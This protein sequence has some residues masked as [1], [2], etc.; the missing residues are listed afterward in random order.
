MNKKILLA[1]FIIVLV[2]I[3]GYLA[4]AKK[5]ISNQQQVV[6]NQENTQ[7]TTSS[8]AQCGSVNYK[9]ITQY[10]YQPTEAEKEATIKSLTCINQALIK[11]TPSSLLINNANQ[12]MI[13]TVKGQSNSG[14]DVGVKKFD[15]GV[16]TCPLSADYITNLQ[17][18][19]IASNYDAT[20]VSNV[21]GDINI[22]ISSGNKSGTCTV[23]K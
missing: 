15:G 17:K 3:V 13:V 16:M 1:I 5:S 19:F 21:I 4:L 9:I 8:I 6:N 23:S 10:N 22:E 12:T 2:G 7:A 11:C 18:K 14:C 20:I